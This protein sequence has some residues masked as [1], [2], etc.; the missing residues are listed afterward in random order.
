MSLPLRV[1]Y[2]SVMHRGRMCRRSLQQDKRKKKKK[3]K[4]TVDT[5]PSTPL[6]VGLV[7]AVVG[8]VWYLRKRAQNTGGRNSTSSTSTR[9]A[10]KFP[11]TA[12]QQSGLP[13]HS[14]SSNNKKNK[15]RRRA[16]KAQ[17]KAEKYVG[18]T[19]WYTT[20]YVFMIHVHHIIPCQM[21]FLSRAG[22][23]LQRQQ[24]RLKEQSKMEDKHQ[25]LSLITHTL[26]QLDEIL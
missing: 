17:K 14:K 21:L 24:V 25:H 16:E 3:A 1:L 15:A 8:T 20:Y 11:D 12:T 23:R 5:S 2:C 13:R 18:R 10:F 26:T 22:K 19:H 9:S 4:K 6:F 7:A